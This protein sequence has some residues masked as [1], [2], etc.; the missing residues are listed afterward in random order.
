MVVSKDPVCRVLVERNSA[1]NKTLGI[2][3]FSRS[4]WRAPLRSTTSSNENRKLEL[5]W[6]G[7][8]P[9]VRALLEV[10]RHTHPDVLFVSE[11]H[12]GR[13]KAE[14]VM[15]RMMFDHIAI[16]ESDGRRG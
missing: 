6:L 16:H 8:A 15:R 9:A 7:R 10:Q 12:L 3:L 13:A 2:Q 5:L 4:D 14:K 1:N 11:T